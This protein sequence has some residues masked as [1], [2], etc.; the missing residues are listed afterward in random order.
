MGGS[1]VGRIVVSPK[2]VVTTTPWH[3]GAAKLVRLVPRS[4]F[5]TSQAIAFSYGV[6][7]NLAVVI[8]IDGVEKNHVALTFTKPT[9][10]RFRSGR[11][12]CMRGNNDMEVA[13]AL[14]VYRDETHRLLV[15]VCMTF[16]TWRNDRP[17]TPLLRRGKYGTVRAFYSIQPGS[18]TCDFLRGVTYGGV[19]GPYS[20][21]VA[22]RGRWPL[23][24][25]PQGYR[26]SNLYDL[27]GWV[28]Y[29][30]T[31][32]ITATLH[33]TWTTKGH[34]P[35]YDPESDGKSQCANPYFSG[36]HRV[37]LF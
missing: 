37:E 4:V 23:G 10:V 36:G 6:A 31:P 26:Y 17:F 25:N 21:G 14:R 3:P 12:A 7:E 30:W 22:Y 20:W 24:F 8:A 15:S 33:V 5:L 34:I 28:G 29:I 13:G 2:Y 9:G 16:Q 19:S 1:H 35:G 18:G 32:A 27:H 11:Y